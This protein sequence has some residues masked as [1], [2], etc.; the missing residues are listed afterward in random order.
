MPSPHLLWS[1]AAVRKS[2]PWSPRFVQAAEQATTAPAFLW[3]IDQGPAAPAAAH[4]SSTVHPSSL[5]DFS[6]RFSGSD[7]LL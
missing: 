2:W 6:I 1:A 3:S 7:L 4:P 5:W